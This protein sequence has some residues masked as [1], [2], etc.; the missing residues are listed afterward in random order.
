MY[1]ILIPKT[2]LVLKT[3]IIHELINGRHLLNN[4][5]LVSGMRERFLEKKDISQQ[6]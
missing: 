4:I 6:Y 3:S 2:M 5:C 1:I